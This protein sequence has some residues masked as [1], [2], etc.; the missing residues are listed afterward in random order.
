M[1]RYK[2][3]D[4]SSRAF[5]SR[6]DERAARINRTFM[7]VQSGPNPLS[8]DEIRTLA[9]KRPEIWGRFARALDNR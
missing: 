9:K 1:A 2:D 5:W 7:E 4:R 8:P 6:A 3:T